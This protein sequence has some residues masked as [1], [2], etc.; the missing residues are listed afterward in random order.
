M[1]EI[2][3]KRVPMGQNENKSKFALLTASCRQAID[4]HRNQCIPRP[5]KLFGV[6]ATS[7]S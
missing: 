3:L 7:V 1:I 6:S 5:Q 2:S 4:Y